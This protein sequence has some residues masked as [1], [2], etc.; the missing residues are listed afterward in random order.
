MFDKVHIPIVGMVENMS[1]FVCDGCGKQHTIFSRG[2]AKAR[3]RQFR[4]AF[5]GEIPMVSAIR[6]CGDKG[7]PILA[8][9]PDSPTGKA[10]LEAAAHL[11]GQLS[12]ASEA[13]D[14]APELKIVTS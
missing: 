8:Q 9:E 10:F 14:K 11:A 2:G 6:E 3:R 7:T 12:I 13:A 4:R 5:L 1:Y